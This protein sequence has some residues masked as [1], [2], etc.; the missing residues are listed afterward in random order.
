MHFR[1]CSKRKPLAANEG[2]GRGVGGVF[3]QLVE[4]RERESAWERFRQTTH[5]D[6]CI[7]ENSSCNNGDVRSTLRLSKERRTRLSLARTF[8]PSSTTSEQ[9]QCWQAKAH[10]CGRVARG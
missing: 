3:Q 1:Q 2:L 5:R 8:G 10:C 6:K 4:G 7:T 9:R